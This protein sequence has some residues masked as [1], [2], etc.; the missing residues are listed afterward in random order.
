MQCIWALQPDFHV[1]STSIHTIAHI[2]VHL[3]GVPLAIELAAS[4]S[5]QLSQ[6]ALLGHLSHR[7]P[8]LTS[9]PQDAPVRQQTLRQ[10][11][12][13]S[14]D[15]LNPWEQWL[16]RH[17]SLFVGGCTLQAVEALCMTLESG[18]ESGRTSILDGVA[19]LV[20]TSLLYRVQHEGEE[21]RFR[22]LE[23]TRE[24]GQ[25]MLARSEETEPIRHA[26]ALCYLK[27]VEQ[28]AHAWEGPQHGTWLERVECDHDNV[29]AAMQWS[30]E[31]GKDGERLEIAFRF[32]AALRSFW[33]VRGYL[34]E[35][36]TFLGRVLAQSEG[37]L[38]SWRSKILND[39]VLLAVSQGDHDWGESLCQEN[40][41]R[42]RELRDSPAVAQTLYLLG[43]IACLKSDFPTAHA[44]LSESLMLS[45]E[46]RQGRN[47]RSTH[48]AGNSKRLPGRIRQGTRIAG[49]GARTAAGTRKQERNRVA[50]LPPS[51]G[52]LSFF[53]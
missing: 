12:A 33:Q 52:A 30:L 22:M 9:G 26:H 40:L 5:K 47:P 51:L 48:L 31:Q 13:W 4:R 46:R 10:T 25:E 37:D 34:N 2:C 49:A 50:A 53:E 39:A 44:R 29:R 11:L 20:D 3:E 28:A 17:L 23:M 27:L 41:L 36:R 14:Y 43:W 8:L 15:L 19:S 45:K 32:G 16:F 1:T 7:L 21:S 6:Q 35:G 38:S 18:D 42:Y 24:Y